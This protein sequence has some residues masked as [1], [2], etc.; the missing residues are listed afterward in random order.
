MIYLK[1][2][3]VVCTFCEW[4]GEEGEISTQNEDGEIELCPQC[5]KTGTLQDVK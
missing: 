2:T 5:G 4:F 1:N 3:D